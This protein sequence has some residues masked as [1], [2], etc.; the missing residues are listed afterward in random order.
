MEDAFLKLFELRDKSGETIHNLVF[1]FLREHGMLD[2]LISIS[3]DGGGN[4][5][6]SNVGFQGRFVKLKNYILWTHCIT[7]RVSLCC[8][9]LIEIFPEIK[10]F[11]MFTNQLVDWFRSSTERLK[12]LKSDEEN[13]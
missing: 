13:D 2:N 11:N 12:L 6:G 1:D 7:H 4:M 5:S 9:Y 3:T 8:K 10:K